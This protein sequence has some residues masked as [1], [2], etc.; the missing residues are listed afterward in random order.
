MS[1]VSS[2]HPQGLASHKPGQMMSIKQ[3]EGKS[4]RAF[5]NDNTNTF[6]MTSNR[7]ANV[8]EAGE[9]DAP[10]KI[11]CPKEDPSNKGYVNENVTHEKEVAKSSRLMKATVSKMAVNSHISNAVNSYDKSNCE[12]SVQG[13]N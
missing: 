4:N 3:E 5:G 7:N 13:D 8:L 2:S 11:N 10:V 9:K 1:S 6:G 12:N